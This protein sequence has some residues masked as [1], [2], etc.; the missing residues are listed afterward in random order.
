MLDS[1]FYPLEDSNVILQF[2]EQGTREFIGFQNAR[3][4]CSCDD[5]RRMWQLIRRKD[6][7]RGMLVN[8]VNLARE[9]G[10]Q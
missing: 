9:F 4:D 6:F 2:R 8:L 1:T 3:G 10:A 5:H 7:P